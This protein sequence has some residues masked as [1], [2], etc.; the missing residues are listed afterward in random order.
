MK[1]FATRLQPDQ[2]LKS[3]LKEFV[4]R[5]AVKAG[6]ILTAVGSL[7]QANLRFAGRNTPQLF[8]ENFEIVSLVGTLSLNGSHLHISL[9]NQEGKTIGGHLAEGSII[10]TMAEIVLGAS[11]DH[12]FTR[13]FDQQTGFLEL[14]IKPSG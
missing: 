8:K 2:D 14:E 10:N 9:A 13:S 1:I 5:N 3:S 6:F 7:K 4:E 12:T 11:Q